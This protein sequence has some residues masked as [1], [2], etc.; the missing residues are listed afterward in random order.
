MELINGMQ[1]MNS[2]EAAEKL[3]V[4]PWTLNKLCRQ[5]RIGFIQLNQRVRAFTQQNIDDYVAGLKREAI[6]G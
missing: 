5:R 1:L 2:M 4:T 3:G 6:N